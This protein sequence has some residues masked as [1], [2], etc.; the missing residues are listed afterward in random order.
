MTT[1][2]PANV[3]FPGWVEQQIRQAIAEGAFDNLPG[4]GKPIPDLGRPQPELAWV[5]NY[6]RRENVDVAALL[7]PALALAKEVED[8]P[9]RLLAEVSESTA[10]RVVEDLNQRIARAH[11]APQDGPPLRVKMI[12]VDAALEDRRLGLRTRGPARR[13]DADG[14]SD[15]GH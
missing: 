3:D 1:R 14:C 7:P 4:A 5:A 6:L 9:G 15:G 11:A 13:S 2:K 10:R 12:D 8:L